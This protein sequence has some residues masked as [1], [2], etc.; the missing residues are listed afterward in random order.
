MNLL[1]MNKLCIFKLLTFQ[2]IYKND[3]ERK[4]SV[5]N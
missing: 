2:P 4:S 5:C 1:K 3:K